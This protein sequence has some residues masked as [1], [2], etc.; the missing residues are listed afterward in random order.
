[1]IRAD[2]ASLLGFGSS[3]KN[4]LNLIAMKKLLLSL[5]LG[6]A[7]ISASAVTPFLEF[8]PIQAGDDF[9]AF[10]FQGGF[11][12]KVHPNIAL[13]LGV[14]LTEK[15]ELRFQSVDSLLRPGRYIRENGQP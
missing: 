2:G 5:A 1:M 9:T 10:N 14:G 3:N 13:G 15:M 4:F 12:G 11:T 6:L 8:Q 7:A